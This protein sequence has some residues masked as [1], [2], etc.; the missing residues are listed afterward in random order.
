MRLI[1]AALLLLI[2]LEAKSLF[3]NDTQ[4][5]TSK[6]IDNLKD[7]IIATQKTRGLTNAYVGTKCK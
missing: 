1:L 6:H 3:S 4:A 2:N 5:Q 7:L